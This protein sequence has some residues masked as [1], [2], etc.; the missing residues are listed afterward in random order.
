MKTKLSTQ[1]KKNFR[2]FDNKKK[3]QKLFSIFPCKIKKT[4]KQKKILKMFDEKKEKE[5]KLLLKITPQE[6]QK[7]KKKC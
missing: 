7:T 6:K 3:D 4:K 1:K 2:M 5:E